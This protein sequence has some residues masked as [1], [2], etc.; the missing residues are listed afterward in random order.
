[1][2]HLGVSLLLALAACSSA[3]PPR[4]VIIGD[5]ISGGL[6]AARY[7]GVFY[8][9]P[10][11]DTTAEILDWELTNLSIPGSGYIGGSGGSFDAQVE[12]AL[13]LDPDI[14][15]IAGGVGDTGR[16][17]GPDAVEA[18]ANA[19]LDALSD[20]PTVYVLSPFPGE[21]GLG[22][23]EVYGNDARRPIGDAI[24]RAAEAHER[25]YVDM[26]NPPWTS[27]EHVH[28][29]QIHLNQAGETYIGERL[30]EVLR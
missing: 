4:A 2:L 15:V 28:G 26:L 10:W 20:V 19:G 14:V 5:S 9:E 24:R 11:P 22:L 29:D 16:P 27:A 1:M 3:T 7:G 25:E 12:A 18:A 8:E 6:E 30:A 21:E 23:N 13:D 17:G